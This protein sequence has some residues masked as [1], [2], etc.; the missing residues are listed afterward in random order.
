M[1]NFFTPL[2][3]ASGAVSG[4]CC[5]KGF[6]ISKISII[7]PRQHNLQTPEFIYEKPT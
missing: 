3:S 5:E 2:Q 1:G 7:L 6:P 4:A